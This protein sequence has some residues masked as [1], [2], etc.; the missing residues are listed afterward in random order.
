MKIAIDAADWHYHNICP[1]Q[2]Q[3]V[4][5]RKS[6]IQCCIAVSDDHVPAVEP[7]A[8][9][10]E[11]AIFSRVCKLLTLNIRPVFVFDGLEDKA[12]SSS[13]GPMR[14]PG[15]C[16]IIKEALDG[17]GVP[18]I[19]ALGEAE[20]ECCKLQKLGLVDAVWSQDSDCRM[21]GCTF[22]IRELRTAR[23]TGK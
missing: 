16:D 3:Y 18:H 6:S 21:F 9:P 1:E 8:H 23:E 5:E 19:D 4:K 2:E 17:L 20:A 11:K 7:A 15:A 22:L 12:K 14:N 10:V 13:K